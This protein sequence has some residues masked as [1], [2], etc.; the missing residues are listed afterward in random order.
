MRKS[1]EKTGILIK[2]IKSMFGTYGL[3]GGFNLEMAQ[4]RNSEKLTGFACLLASV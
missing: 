2:M 1:L 3:T 4:P